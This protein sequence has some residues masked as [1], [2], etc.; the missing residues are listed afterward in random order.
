MGGR[1]GSG[2]G[3]ASSNYCDGACNE[4]WE[5][6]NIEGVLAAADWNGDCDQIVTEMAVIDVT[7][8]GLVLREIA[9]GVTAE[10]VQAATEAKLSVAT[11]LKLMKG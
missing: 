9:P 2:G 10:Q 6:E 7:P 11:D 4:G 8:G 3:R 1:D 5:T